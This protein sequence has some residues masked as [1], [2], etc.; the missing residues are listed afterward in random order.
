[1]ESPRTVGVSLSVLVSM[2]LLSMREVRV[3][4]ASGSCMVVVLDEAMAV[5]VAWVEAVLRPWNTISSSLE[6]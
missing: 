6:L 5:V 2:M 1:M 3:G 4:V